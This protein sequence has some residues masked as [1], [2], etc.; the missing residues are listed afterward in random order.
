MAKND[1]TEAKEG[2]T[3]KKLSEKDR[4][5]RGQQLGAVLEELEAFREEA[6]EQKAALKTRENALA[7]RVAKLRRAVVSGYEDVD[8]QSDLNLDA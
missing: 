6:K 8:A 5:E 7:G 1:D 3:R 2:T 4:N